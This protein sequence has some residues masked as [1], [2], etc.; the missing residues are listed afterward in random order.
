MKYIDCK[1]IAQK[2]KDEIKATGVVACL[3][4]ISVGDNP[5]SASYI[6]GKIK[7]ATEIGFRCIHKHIEAINREQ[8]L[9]ELI[10]FLEQL[11]YSISVDG[12]I[13]QLPLPFGL[14]FDDIKRYLS[15]QKD[16]DGFLTDSIFHPCTPDGILQMLN[17]IN[18][19]MDGKLCVIAGRS[20]IVGKPL[21]EMMTSANATVV[22]CHSHTP[23]N[24]LKQLASNADI[25]VSAVGQKD[26][27]DSSIFK[28][29][30][31]VI[32][33]GI[34]RTDQGIRGDITINPDSN[35]ILITPVPG[36]I[37]LLTRAML[38]KHLLTAYQKYHTWREI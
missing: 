23:T 9:S 20:D 17:E 5:A 38:M 13:V 30:A 1:S 8:V 29:G 34:N 24:L 22:L 2:W 18:V 31:V 28:N 10:T 11:Q 35:D 19:D 27:I 3:Y 16:V 4:V 12:I 26:F 36:G 32:D 25:F 6:K 14:T 37:G 15:V 21:S 33:V 7:D